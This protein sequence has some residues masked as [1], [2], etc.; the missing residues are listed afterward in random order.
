MKTNNIKR[1]VAALALCTT[2]LLPSQ[3]AFA[4]NDAKTDVS[5]AGY[6]NYISSNAR[7][8]QA[9]DSVSALDYM[10]SAVGD[11][12]LEQMLDDYS[13]V[14]TST[15]DT[16]EAFKVAVDGIYDEVE[17]YGF[18]E[19]QADALLTSQ[20]ELETGKAE[21]TEFTPC[22][23]SAL[24]SSA[25]EGTDESKL[26]KLNDIELLAT[27]D[28]SSRYDVTGLGYEVKS[29]QGYNK[30][31]TYF[32]PGECNID[33]AGKKG[34]AGYMFYTLTWN[35]V[36]QDLGVVYDQGYWQPCVMGHYTG[37]AKG[38]AKL[39]EGAK[40]YFKIWIGTDT[41]I[42]FQGIDGNNFNNIIFQGVY[43]SWN[44]LPPSGAGV[45][46]NRQITYAANA[47][48]GE[49]NNCR[50]APSGYYIKN[51]R[52]DQAYLYN[53]H[54][55]ERYQDSNT[56]SNSRGKFGAPW[57]PVSY[58]TINSNTRWSSENVTIDLR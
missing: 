40:L 8:L 34:I 21:V 54:S 35:D 12:D 38:G 20:V 7:T 10:K 50:Y 32:Y 13:T 25:L 16:Y 15:N 23:P 57:A 56:V 9:S 2:L 29:T 22:E 19:A 30:T 43:T 28:T 36:A 4:A 33:R 31:T 3:M 47:T 1:K 26:K 24:P 39:A 17:Q 18:D 45:A 58:V 5:L 55:T 48:D 51:A 46:F 44:E 27:T 41:Q 42:Y 53:N 37:Y 14:N 11:A 49:G 52:F 6:E